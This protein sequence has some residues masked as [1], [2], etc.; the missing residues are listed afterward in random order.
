VKI[1]KVQL[2]PKR[3]IRQKYILSLKRN[4]RLINQVVHLVKEK[5]FPELTIKRKTVDLITRLAGINAMEATYILE[6]LRRSINVPGDIGEF[7]VAQGLTSALLAHHLLKTKKK[8]WLF[9]SFEG[10]SAPTHKDKLIND[11]YEL[12]DIKKYKGRMSCPSSMVLH[13][14]KKIRFPRN[15][16]RLIKGWVSETLAKKMGPKKVAFA[17]V[18]VDFHD[19]TRTILEFLHPRI[20]RGGHIFVDD[21][22]FFSSG[23]KSAVKKFLKKYS[24]YYKLIIPP[25]YAGFFCILKRRKK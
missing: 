12:G 18:D 14:L 25:K 4:Q 24:R 6:Y 5:N 10:L 13:E 2:K 16:C 19:P 9:D 15:R 8:L 22:G 17:L 11:I 7:G 1:K 20:S 3:T 23:V 21:Y